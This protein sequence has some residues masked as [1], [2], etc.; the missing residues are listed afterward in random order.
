MMAKNSQGGEV[1]RRIS[2]D[3]ATKNPG[4]AARGFRFIRNRMIAFD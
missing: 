4:R 2:T 3:A 1:A